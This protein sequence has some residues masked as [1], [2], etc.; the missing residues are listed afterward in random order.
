[1]RSRNIPADANLYYPIG[2][3]AFLNCVQYQVLQLIFGKKKF[4]KV[5]IHGITFVTL[6]QWV[7]PIVLWFSAK[8]LK[9]FNG[10][11]IY[12]FMQV[13]LPHVG[14]FQGH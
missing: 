1:M 8:E 4:D 3:L 6:V 7:L 11:A 12:T 10:E 5:K 14:F 13:V 9:I 2:K